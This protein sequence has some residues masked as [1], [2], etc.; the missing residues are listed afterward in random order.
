MNL[1]VIGSGAA[2][3]GC[4]RALAE[5][6]HQITVLDVG[7][8]LEAPGEALKQ[9]MAASNPADWDA[10]I[11]AM[12]SEYNFD[13]KGMNLRP[14]FR[15][16]YAYA[17]EALD[18]DTQEHCKVLQSW[19]KG[20]L[21][22]VWGAATLPPRPADVKDW[23]IPWEKWDR[24]LGAVTPMLGIAG[25]KDNLDAFYPRYVHQPALKVSRQAANVRARMERNRDQL[26]RDGIWFGDARLA[27]EPDRCRY[28][29]MCICGC[30]DDAFFEGRAQLR[31]WIDAGRVRYLPEH[32]V[33]QL[34]SRDSQVIV[35]GRSSSTGQP[36][37]HEAD[38]VF[39]G[40]GVLGD[41]RILA[42]SLPSL[43][44]AR[45]AFHPYVLAPILFLDRAGPVRAERLYTVAQLF[46]A[47]DDPEISPRNVHIQ[48]S[49]YNPLI[50]KKLKRMFCFLG[51]ASDL[52]SRA[53]EGRIGAIQALFHS[54]E[55]PAIECAID[56]SHRPVRL[57]LKGY[58]VRTSPVHKKMNR[59]LA[60][61][62]SRAG[63][64]GFWPLP[65]MNY[66]G[67][68][69]EGQHVGSSFPMTAT[70]NGVENSTN[71]LGE[72]RQLPRVHIVDGSVL[73]DLPSATITF[74]IMANAYRIT[75]D[76]ARGES[77][78]KPR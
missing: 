5:S 75:R 39:L 11:R 26:N 23:G 8:E 58:D 59:L 22:N 32:L 25:S 13:A 18:Q 76:V 30:P 2:S 24:A 49:T 60:R 51:P 78:L 15:S 73:P 38:R 42:R 19:A 35:S 36:F 43:S 21:L 4:L 37:R 50:T 68:P 67:T 61:L 40:T 55:S 20:G 16:L 9:R 71:L 56:A 77:E 52:A 65:V 57:R 66:P 63:S 48:L 69:G 3:L 54:T 10:G 34:E 64:L 47:V 17:T 31:K 12:P 74:T 41:L 28:C 53:F 45:I 33:E 14:S 29:G 72:H 44:D 70:P 7:R 46:V 6:G 62:R 1:T 27:I